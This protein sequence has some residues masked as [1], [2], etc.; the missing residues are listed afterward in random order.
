[1]GKRPKEYEDMEVSQLRNDLNKLSTIV[2]EMKTIL[3][4]SAGLD[5]KGMMANVR[6]LKADVANIK[7]EIEE[8]KR[9]K[10]F[11]NLKTLQSR[12]VA[13]VVLLSV[14]VSV[15]KTCVDLYNGT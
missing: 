1:M 11:V 15:V 8:I 13:F 14:I 4:G 5:Y 2:V 3:G 9:S 6:D 7:L 12:F 10:S